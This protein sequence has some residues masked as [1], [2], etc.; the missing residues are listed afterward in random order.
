M[1]QVSSRLRSARA[2][3]SEDR[4]PTVRSGARTAD[5]V[6]ALILVASSLDLS[7]VAQALRAIAAIDSSTVVYRLELFTEMLNALRLHESDPSVSLWDAAWATR[8]RARQ[9]GRDVELR[10]VSRALLIKGLEFEHAIV[11][12][13]NGPSNRR[14]SMKE[15]YVAITRGTDTLS[16]AV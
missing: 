1:T 9:Q 8:D 2:A 12:D 7:P 3:F 15:L 16:V 14:L 10:T 4:T 6:E 5:A 13:V 11:A